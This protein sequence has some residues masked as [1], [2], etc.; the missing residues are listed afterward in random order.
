M[1]L[2]VLSGALVFT[3][4]PKNPFL[5]MEGDNVTLEWRYSFGKD[6]SLSQALFEKEK[7][8]V[9]RYNPS[10]PP[11]IKSSY[12]GRIFV[13]ITN[14]YTSIILLGVKRTDEGSYR[15]TVVS[16]R[17]RERIENE[18]EISILCKYKEPIKNNDS[19]TQEK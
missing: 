13:N 4:E 11:W 12:R 18:L 5:A 15:F 7:Q 9:D 3:E 14:D 17:D 6:D 10:R 1:L 8:I 2:F 16:E 19:Q